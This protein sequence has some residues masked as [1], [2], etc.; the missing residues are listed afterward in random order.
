MIKFVDINTTKMLTYTLG[1]ATD[2]YSIIYCPHC[3]A[4]NKVWAEGVTGS[5]NYC[6]VCGKPI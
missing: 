2:S 1:N 5:D 6:V 4:E 3:G